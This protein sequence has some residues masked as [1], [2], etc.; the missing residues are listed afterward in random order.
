M[1]KHWAIVDCSSGTIECRV[2][3][4]PSPDF[5]Q[6]DLRPRAS[7]G[8]PTVRGAGCSVRAECR[9]KD[10]LLCQ[11]LPRTNQEITPRFRNMASIALSMRMSARGLVVSSR[12]A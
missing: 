8:A 12:A 1:L 5:E 6:R 10:E 2:S 3:V 9:N 7:Q 4:W 11:E